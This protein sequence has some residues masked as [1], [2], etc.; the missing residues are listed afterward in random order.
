MRI[1]LT[2][3]QYRLIE[4]II[5]EAAIPFSKKIEKGGFIQ[6]INKVGDKETS[7]TLKVTNIYGGGK[8]IQ[9][10]NKSGDYI[11]N[12]TGSLDEDA[13]TFTV[14]KGAEY[15]AGYKDSAGK[16][17][18][19]EI[20]GGSKMVVKNVLQ[21]TVSDS[22][23]NVVDEIY[24]KMGD[25][26]VKTSDTDSE[27]IN[28]RRKIRKELEAEKKQREKRVF[29]LVMNDP[30]LKKAFYHQP[31]ILKGLLNY[32]KAKGI[33]PAQELIG[34]YIAGFEPK[35]VGDSDKENKWSEFKVNKSVIFEI[36]DKPI[37]MSY[38]EDSIILM[39]GKNYKGRYVG[40]GYLTGKYNKDV[41]YKI[42]MKENSGGDIYK[43]T[44]KAFFK[45]EDE[46][47][48]DKMEDIVIRIKDYNY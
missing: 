39:V 5:E 23:K 27:T 6:V 11:I 29:D 43:G 37:R 46:S 35:D 24:T 33:G 3:D 34:K 40:K 15:R 17:H 19:E 7:N 45:E 1:I 2:E 10:S 41:H 44:I 21:V 38:G 48:V 14:L 18:P 42:Y 31:K 12:V 8:F 20:V 13:N 32:G 22:A 47:I 30:T 26:V 25:E 4:R 9:G 16:V 28:N 36:V